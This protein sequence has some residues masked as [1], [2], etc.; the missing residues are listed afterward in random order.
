ME[1][2]VMNTSNITNYKLKDLVNPTLWTKK[3]I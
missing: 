3:E 2:I 1:D